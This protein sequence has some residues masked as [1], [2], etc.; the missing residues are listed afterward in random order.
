[1]CEQAHRAPFLSNVHQHFQ[2]E[3][4]ATLPRDCCG[5]LEQIMGQEKKSRI[6]AVTDSVTRFIFPSC[7]VVGLH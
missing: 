2:V 1:M 4:G 7:A 6:V 3:L 5:I